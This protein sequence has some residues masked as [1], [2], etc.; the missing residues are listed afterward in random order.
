[1][2]K[3]E[4]GTKNDQKNQKV[5]L[6]VKKDAAKDAPTAQAD[7]D[8]IMQSIDNLDMLLANIQTN[9]PMNKE[10]ALKRLGDQYGIQ[11]PEPK[12]YQQP[13]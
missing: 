11:A 3:V 4:P 1:M 12:P 5:P 13:F 7:E 2:M 6:H 10:K 9:D 8:Q